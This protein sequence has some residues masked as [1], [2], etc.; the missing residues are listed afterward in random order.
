MLLSLKS[1]GKLPLSLETGVTQ[2]RGNLAFGETCWEMS[3]PSGGVLQVENFLL[4]AEKWVL[5]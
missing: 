2:K 1:D 3:V 4:F 5:E